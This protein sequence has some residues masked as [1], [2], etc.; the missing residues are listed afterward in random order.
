[1]P[2]YK[3]LRVREEDYDK[4]RE[5]QRLISQNGLGSI[6][7]DALRKQSPVAPPTAEGDPDSAAVA[8]TLGFVIGAGAAALAALV[9]RHLERSGEDSEG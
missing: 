1:M 5:A 2:N 4:L 7:W 8:L 9:V 6:D 3:M